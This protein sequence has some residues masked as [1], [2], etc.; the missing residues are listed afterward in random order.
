[1]STN[2]ISDIIIKDL[3]SKSF[4]IF[5]TTYQGRGMDEADVFGINRNG[6]MYEF[7]IKQSRSDFLAE[8]RNKKDK[9]KKLQNRNAIK[10]YDEWKNEK[11]TEGTYELIRIP[12]RYFFV[13]PKDLISIDEVPEYAGLIY[14]DSGYFGKLHEVKHAKLLHRNKANILVYERVASIL[15][16]RSIFGCS[17]Y[18]YRLNQQ[19]EINKP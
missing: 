7:E 11:R 2:E 1:M 6:Y 9:H 17:Y 18:T 3:L 13:C 15:S 12:N 5:L 19:K 14:I 10:V 4:P 8:F 16:Q